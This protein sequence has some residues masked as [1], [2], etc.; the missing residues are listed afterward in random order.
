MIDT[1]KTKRYNFAP[2]IVSVDWVRGEAYDALAAERDRLREALLACRLQLLQSNNDSE[3][4]Q[5]ALEMARAALKAVKAEEKPQTH[6]SGCDG[7]HK[8]P[9]ACSCHQ[10]GGKS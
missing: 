8:L 3:Y 7:L 2:T 4:A 5:E 1:S 9:C 10:T 6:I